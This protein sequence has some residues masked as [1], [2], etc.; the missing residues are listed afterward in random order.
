MLV[1][2]N[3]PKGQVELKLDKEREDSLANG[4]VYLNLVLLPEYISLPARSSA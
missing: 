1:L 2:S 3:L 4:Q